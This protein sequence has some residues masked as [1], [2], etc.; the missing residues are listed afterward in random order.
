MKIKGFCLDCRWYPK[1]G[2]L[3]TILG[4]RHVA[5]LCQ[6]RLAWQGVV[7]QS[8]VSGKTPRRKRHFCNTMRLRNGAC[9]MDRKLF[10][11]KSGKGGRKT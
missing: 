4:T 2:I 5:P 10:E 1:R 7:R 8:P 6:H 11:P 3:D 9:G